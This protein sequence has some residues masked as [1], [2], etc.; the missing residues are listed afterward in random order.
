MATLA[1]AATWTAAGI[2]RRAKSGRGE[3]LLAG[4]A[5]AL[6]DRLAGGELAVDLGHAIGSGHWW[7]GLVTLL[8]LMGA[9][10]SLVS[11]VPVLPGV[12]PAPLSGEARTER[13][14]DAIQP[15]GLGSATGRTMPPTRAVTRLAEPPER[16][17]IELVARVGGDG[18]AGALRRAGLSREDADTVLALVSGAV[19]PRSLTGGTELQLVMGRR[20]TRSV[21]RPLE[22]LAF[23][24]AFDLRLEV[25]RADD[26]NLRLVRIPIAVDDT[27]LRIQGQ[28]GRSLHRSARAAGV[29]A[30]VLADYLRQIGFVL[31][32]QREVGARDRFDII[33]EHRRAETG[34]TE[35]GRLLYAGLQNGS[36]KI[37]LM[38]WGPRG[39][40][41]RD[42]GNSARQGLMR[43]PVDGARLSSGFGM[44][45]HPILGF[46][47]LHR[48]VDFAAPTGTPV[49]ASAG[50][51][52]VRAGWGGGYGN[53]I[54]IDHGRGIVTR[55]AHLSRMDVRVGQQVNQG[56][57]IGAVGSTGMST[58]PHLHYE[59]IRNGQPIDPRSNRLLVQGPV[60]AG[61]DL[62]R[63]RGEMDRLLAVRIANGGP[64]ETQSA[65]AE[66]ETAPEQPQRR[67]TRR[68]V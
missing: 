57:R 20:E 12:A 22:H 46:S 30:S 32:I 65:E 51:R 35:M 19:N 10:V 11:Q 55:Y 62:V 29:P 5:Q 37:R 39:E 53:M 6:A 36:R 48:G 34:E 24:A 31:D 21:P 26:G 17:R 27:P 3:R 58:G 56:Q 50:G 1:P 33:I 61:Q 40:F 44:R 43:T 8:V 18:M 41:F 52:V 14:A 64:A 9:G 68:R 7:R 23:R 38:R 66:Q 13:L 59:V 67:E 49:L 63:F 15:M 54:D 60:L 42:D 28:V 16:P 25:V 4:R 47:R 2:P 45:T